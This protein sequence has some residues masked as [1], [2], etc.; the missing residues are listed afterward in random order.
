MHIRPRAQQCRNWAEQ[1]GF[2]LL[3]PGII[4]LPPYH[5]GMSLER[6]G[7]GMEKHGK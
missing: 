1:V 6:P 7:A 3:D 2:R 4:D 5:Y